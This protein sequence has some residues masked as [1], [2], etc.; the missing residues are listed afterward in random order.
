LPA[1]NTAL[2]L[3]LLF[4]TDDVDA[5]HGGRRAAAIDARAEFVAAIL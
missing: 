4:E 3:A 1:S 5:G 2:L